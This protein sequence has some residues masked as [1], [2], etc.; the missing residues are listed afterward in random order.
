MV[1][2]PP[3]VKPS[4]RL[5][6]E[7]SSLKPMKNTFTHGA[8]FDDRTSNMSIPCLRQ[9]GDLRQPDISQTSKIRIKTDYR[10]L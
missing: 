9:T 4:G 1:D 10:P 8:T 5:Y 6:L 2:T 3:G 7:A